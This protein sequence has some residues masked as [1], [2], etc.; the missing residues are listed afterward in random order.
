MLVPGED[1]AKV[2]QIVKAHQFRGIFS[3][4]TRQS[5][6]IPIEITVLASEI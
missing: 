2:N 5:G 1:R 3:T 6:Q 4:N